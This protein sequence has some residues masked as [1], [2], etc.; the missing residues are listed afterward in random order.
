MTTRPKTSSG[1]SWADSRR[2]V[3]C[4]LVLVVATSCPATGSAT[5]P[6]VRSPS[7]VRAH[8][9][10]GGEAAPFDGILL[11]EDAYT[12]LREKVIRLEGEL[13]ACRGGAH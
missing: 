2:L 3:L 12:G 10:T 5:A 6:V 1:R 4:L 7:A 8:W 9:M 11:S 13:A